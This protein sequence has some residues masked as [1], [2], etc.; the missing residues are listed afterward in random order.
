MV[1]HIVPFDDIPEWQDGQSICIPSLI[2]SLYL[3]LAKAL[4]YRHLVTTL[5]SKGM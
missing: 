1:V 2:E 5:L 4:S 3:N